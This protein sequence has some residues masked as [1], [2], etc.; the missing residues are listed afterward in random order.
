M[1]TIVP[2]SLTSAPQDVLRGVAV[3]TAVLAVAGCSGEQQ[4][5]PTSTP[6]A[7]SSGE[8]TES[9]A[10]SVT[11]EVPPEQQQKLAD[12]KADQLCGLVSP[13]DLAKLA[14]PVEPGRPREAGVAPPIRGCTFAGRN[15]VRSILIGSQPEGYGEAGV[16]AVNLGGIRGT[17]VLHA[18]DCTVLTGVFGGTLQVV[19]SATEADSDDCDTAQSVTRYLVAGLVR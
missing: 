3:L 10:P 19:V 15:G 5:T 17:K 7:T 16:K 13:E 8:S 1:P 11:R 4:S 2:V 9:V 14:F 12:L 6:P 18:N